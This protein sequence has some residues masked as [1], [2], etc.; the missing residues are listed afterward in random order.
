MTLPETISLQN[1]TAGLRS[2]DIS[3]FEYLDQLEA[4]FNAVEPEVQ[5]FVPEPSRFDRLRREA[6]QLLAAYPHPAGRPPLFGV[7]LGVKDIFHVEGF[8][9]RAG[10]RLDSRLIQGSE[11]TAV[12]QL[13]NAGALVLGKTVTTEFAYFAPGPTRNPHNLQHTPGGSSSGSA[14]AVA[15]GLGSLAF[16]TQTIGSINRPASFCGVVGYKPSHDRISKDGVIP[17]SPSADHVGFFVPRSGDAPL[18]AAL[19]CREWSAPAPH[20]SPVLAVPEGPYLSH[21]SEEGLAH[22]EAT[23]AHLIEAGFTVKRVPIMPDFEQIYKRHND[24]VAAEAADTHREWY[25][26]N[27]NLYHAKTAELIK[28]GQLLDQQTLLDARRSQIELRMLLAEVMDSSGIDLWLSPAAVGPAPRGL[29]STGDPV[30][31]LPWTHAGIP[32]MTLPSGF[33]ANGLPLGL[34]LAA[35]WYGDEEL[36]TWAPLLEQTLRS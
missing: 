12:T 26:G 24:L 3:L 32:T 19:L 36:L 23:C 34:Q 8:I 11:S 6:E 18:V 7:P 31:N 9:T 33:S 22:F 16:G 2:G 10:S 28:K 17:V 27:K 21:A 1:L 13:K 25:P 35:R 14:A 15:A 5:A 4:L 29:E 20:H 30:M